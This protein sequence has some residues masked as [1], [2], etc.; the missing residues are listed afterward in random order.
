MEL[1]FLFSSA[2][3]AIA[4]ASA[5][6]F[7]TA[8]G[9]SASD[10][11]FGSW[12]LNEAKSQFSSIAPAVSVVRTFQAASGGWTRILETRLTPEGGPILVE[13]IAAYD[14]GKYPIFISHGA[15]GRRTKSDDTVSFRRVNRTTVEGAFRNRGNKT[16]EFTRSVS[17]DEQTLSV[18]ISGIDS[19]GRRIVTL[20]VYDRLT[21]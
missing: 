14:G 6:V 9:D 12:P 1:R 7:S 10:P 16:A 21:T 4:L 18:K 20:L 2:P 11:V 3:L 13:Y 15:T 17:D 19:T 8:G 5:V